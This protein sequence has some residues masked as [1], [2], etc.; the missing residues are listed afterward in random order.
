[1]RNLTD[2]ELF[3]LCQTYGENALKWRRRFTGLLPEVNRR[4]L[5]EKKGFASIFEFAK[6]LCGLS[7][8]QVRR[9]LNLEAKFKDKPA[10]HQALTSGEVS[11]NKLARI[12][13]VA[14]S[15]N[16]EFWIEKSKQLPNRALETLVNDVKFESQDD[17][18][19]PKSE[20]K[21]VHVHRLQL[22]DGVE[23][24]LLELQQKGIDVNRELREFL[25]ERK[26]NWRRKKKNWN[27]FPQNPATSPSKS[28]GTS[29]KNTA[30]NA[31]SRTARSHPPPSITPG[32]SRSRPVTTPAI[33][34]RFAASTTPSRM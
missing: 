33:W 27:K 24:E 1:M 14:T 30:Q 12:A 25:E 23:K 28:S 18:F 13:S 4:K 17:L 9:V 19:K 34:R 21:F 20:S 15:E 10:L 6:K 8:E 11:I 2:Q 16:E 29:I 26:R 31:P 7:E 22:D 3:E 32:A 5:Y